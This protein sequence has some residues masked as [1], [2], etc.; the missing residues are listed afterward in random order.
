[1][2]LFPYFF[3]ALCCIS[4]LKVNGQGFRSPDVIKADFDKAFIKL[5]STL[6]D[7]TPVKLKVKKANVNSAANNLLSYLL[8]MEELT[9]YEDKISADTRELITNI[10]EKDLY[11]VVLL[12]RS[13]KEN[14][15]VNKFVRNKISEEL[16][17]QINLLSKNKYPYYTYE[18][19]NKKYI[20]FVSIRR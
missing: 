17:D 1:M 9:K 3:L 5:D 4:A 15:E 6:L 2:K 20:N 13:L 11:I 16:S 19:K 10:E 8:E 18:T 14:L 7:T 12:E